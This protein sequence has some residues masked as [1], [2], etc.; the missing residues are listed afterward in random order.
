MRAVGSTRIETWAVLAKKKMNI[1]NYLA[2]ENTP[3]PITRDLNPGMQQSFRAANAAVRALATGGNKPKRATLGPRIKWTDNQRF[4]LGQLAATTS[5]ANAVK[6][7]QE[8][9][10]LA[11]ESTIRNFRTYYLK[12]LAANPDLANTT[13]GAISAKKGGETIAVRRV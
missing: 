5:T 7:A 11:N 4:V 12:S 2:N 8:W 1:R 3:V 6:K 10:P 13:H 9:Y